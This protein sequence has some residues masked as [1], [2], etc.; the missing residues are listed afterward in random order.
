[1]QGRGGGRPLN[2]TKCRRKGLRPE[3][4]KCLIIATGSLERETHP[5]HQQLKRY[6]LSGSRELRLAVAT[7]GG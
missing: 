7:A 1:M 3:E 2:E 6:T 5:E 4:K